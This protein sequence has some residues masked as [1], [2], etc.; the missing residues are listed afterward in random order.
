MVRG[1]QRRERGAAKW[2]WPGS[3]TDDGAWEER[4]AIGDGDRLRRGV[5]G[6]SAAKDGNRRWHTLEREETDGVYGYGEWRRRAA[7]DRNR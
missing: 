4:E 7:E 5:G 2:R 6:M 1:E 3:G